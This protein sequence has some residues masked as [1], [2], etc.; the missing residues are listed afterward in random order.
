MV[1]LKGAKKGDATLVAI[2]EAPS[3]IVATRGAAR[4]P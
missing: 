2:M 4:I 1:N 3:G